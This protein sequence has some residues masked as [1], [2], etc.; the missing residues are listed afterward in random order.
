MAGAE[1]GDSLPPVARVQAVLEERSDEWIEISRLLPAIVSQFGVTVGCVDCP[2]ALG[3]TEPSPP[4]PDGLTT[5]MRS[6]FLA[7][8]LKLLFFS[9]L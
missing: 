3:S 2:S 5:V 8:G 9:H 4:A 6:P 1:S 7:V